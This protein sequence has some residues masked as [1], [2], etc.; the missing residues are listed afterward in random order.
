MIL[1]YNYYFYQAVL[2]QSIC[3]KIIELGLK[4]ID[5]R[6]SKYGSEKVSQ[7]MA[8]NTMIKRNID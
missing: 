3:N 1:K 8:V 2:K 6:K 5:A 4:E 7:K